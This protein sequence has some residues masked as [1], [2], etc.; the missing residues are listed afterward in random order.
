MDTQRF[1]AGKYSHGKE[2]KRNSKFHKP[3]HCANCLNMNGCCF[4]KD[5]SPENPL[6]ENCHCY[7]EDIGIP[8]VKTLCAVQKFTDYIFN[9][10]NDK[11][12]KSDV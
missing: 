5:K 11:G 4:V 10:G 12:K 2:Y 3:E 7:Y 8:D 1:C 9:E 6:H